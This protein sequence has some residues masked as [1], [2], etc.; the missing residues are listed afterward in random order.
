MI[1]LENMIFFHICPCC[2]CEIVIKWIDE[3]WDQQDFE[4]PDCNYNMEQ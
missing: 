3:L 4:C 1:Y 2:E